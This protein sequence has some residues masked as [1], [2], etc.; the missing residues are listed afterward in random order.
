LS[1]DR[2]ELLLSLFDPSGVGLEIGP[3]HNPLLPKS[4]GY[5]VEIL[6]HL[7]AEELRLKYGG[8]KGVDVSKIETVDYVSDGGSMSALI[9]K[10]SAFDFVVGSHVVEH[11]TDLLGFLLDCEHL[12][13][14]SGD[15]VL[16]VPDKRFAFDAL[17]PVTMT[18]DVLQAHLEGRKRHTPGKVFDEIAYNVLRGG[19]PGWLPDDSG[20]V[21]FAA[22]L[23]TA[24][25]LFDSAAQ[26]EKF[27]D[28]H[29][30]QFTPSSFRLM[31][32]DLY[33]IHAIRLQEKSFLS[34]G[35]EFYIVLSVNA[36][37][38]PLDRMTLLRQ[39][40]SEQHAINVM[41][42]TSE[43]YTKDIYQ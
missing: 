13:K 4:E 31:I 25:E 42:S 7:P 1:L 36:D 37:G 3:S 15:L 35:G 18:G 20:E 12:L 23:G 6:D 2:R 19:L 29:A 10:E 26:T 16:A 21:S 27:F 14:D 17:R 33:E 38:C 34:V 30:W 41:R 8:N 39:T 5:R 24:L 43:S 28:I 40:I 9:G 32:R 22:S 11:M